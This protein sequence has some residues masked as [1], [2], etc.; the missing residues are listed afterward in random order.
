MKD[1]SLLIVKFKF[2]KTNLVN[3]LEFD[4]RSGK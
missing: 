1:M 2:H 3:A 4:A